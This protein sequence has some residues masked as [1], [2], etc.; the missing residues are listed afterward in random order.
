L[1]ACLD[2]QYTDICPNCGQDKELVESSGWCISCTK[3]QGLC[4]DCGA[5]VP[6]NH[7]RILCWNCKE[8]RWFTKYG[9]LIEYLMITGLSLNRARLMVADVVRPLC[10]VCQ[11]PIKGGTPGESLFCS[12]TLACKRVRNKYRRL[13]AR[14][15]APNRAIDQAFK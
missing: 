7:Q 15:M 10:I 2:Y 12:A 1:S 8:E 11:G 6:E 9:D 14:G 13:I 5:V 4:I 3:E